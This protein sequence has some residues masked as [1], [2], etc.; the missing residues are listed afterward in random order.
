M[1]PTSPVMPGSE[2]IEILI[3]KDQPQYV[4][5]P[6]VYLDR[7]DGNMVTRFRLSDEERSLVAAGGDVVLQQLTFWQHFQPVNLQIVMPDDNPVLL[8]EIV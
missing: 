7:P 6:A 8:D 3:A 2:S 5:L 4:T 1:T